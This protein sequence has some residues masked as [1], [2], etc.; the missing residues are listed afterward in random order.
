MSTHV[1][2]LAP[3]V[4][5]LA[6]SAP[7]QVPDK[8]TNL[9][10]LPKDITKA[11]LVARMRGMASGL[12]VR[13]AH[14]HVGPDNLEGMDFAV[15]KKDEKKAAREML[16]MVAAI[17]TQF[18]ATLPGEP[19]PQKVDCFTCHRGQAEPPRALF[20]VLGEVAAS[21]GAAAAVEEFRRLKAEHGASGIYDFRD[22]TLNRV[23]TALLETGKVDEALTVL[24]ANAEIYPDAGLTQ[25]L[26][27]QAYLKKNDLPRAIT[28]LER[29]LAINPADAFVKRLLEE[30]RA[31]I[32]NP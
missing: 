22:R 27:G 12:G 31:K 1:R 4:L 7:A 10:V 3:V 15:D 25:Q 20:V 19:D 32:P 21:K 13:C 26:L 6:V 5:A 8:F 14:C 28:H 11:E 18:L 16:R 9:Q 30:T 17:N 29:A 23:A 24:S 2:F